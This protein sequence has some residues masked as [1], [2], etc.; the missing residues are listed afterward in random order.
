MAK[1]ALTSA[2]VVS[3]DL[4]ALNLDKVL[5]IFCAMIRQWLMWQSPHWEKWSARIGCRPSPAWAYAPAGKL[6]MA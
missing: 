5:R 4:L 1:L 3:I 2:T 6:R